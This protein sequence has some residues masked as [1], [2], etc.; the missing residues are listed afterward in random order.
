MKKEF[1][2]YLDLVR[3]VAAALVFIAHSNDRLVIAQHLPFAGHA[4][5]AVI[6]FFI[7]SGYV[8]SYITAEREKTALS[9]WSS[10]LSRFYSLVIPALCLTPLLDMAGQS[11]MP[12]MYA[13]RTTN[14]FAWFR[15]LI[16]FVYLNEMWS[17][18]IMPFSNVPFWSLCYEMSYYALFAAAT[19]TGGKVRVWLLAG[20]CLLIGPKILLLAPIWALGVVLHR[21]KALEN[22][23]AWL[24]WA[25]FSFSL[26]GYWLFQHYQMTEYGITLLQHMVGAKWDR[27][28]SFSRPFM[29]DYPLAL[30]VSANFIGFRGIAPAFRPLL[31]AGE[32][33]IRWIATFTFPLYVL[34][35]PFLLFY[36]SLLHGDP[37]T[38]LFYAGVIACTLLSVG[39]IGYMVDRKRYQLRA[40]IEHRLKALTSTPWWQKR[41]STIIRSRPLGI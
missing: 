1:S 8:I 12:D 39:V 3:F 27:L 13:G 34:H 2:I 15:F 19:F 31:L 30:I 35:Q 40:W 6:V 16:S 28:A 36:A 17:L 20:L 4:R 33:P 10:R 24:Y 38:P 9:Y 11:L 23:P 22:L 29:T 14:D 41:I 32:R 5:A 18:S 26:G 37:R 21:W 7:L 25:L